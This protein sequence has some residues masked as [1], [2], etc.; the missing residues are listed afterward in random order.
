M[1]S[2]LPTRAKAVFV[3]LTCDLPL[4]YTAHPHSKEHLRGNFQHT[5]VMQFTLQV[6]PSYYYCS[7]ANIKFKVTIHFMAPSST[8]S[9][10]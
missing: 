2:T 8:F 5:C 10:G 6:E 4:Q 3:S 7:Q 9:H 1:S